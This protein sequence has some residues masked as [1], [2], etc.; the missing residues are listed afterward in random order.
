MCGFTMFNNFKTTV[1][2]PLKWP[3]LVLHIISEST[4]T[5][6]YVL[7]PSGYIP[8]DVGVKRIS[9]PADLVFL[10]LLPCPVGID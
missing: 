2:T 5:D 3:G 8:D 6:T 7:N 4:S 9:A 1:D 10:Y